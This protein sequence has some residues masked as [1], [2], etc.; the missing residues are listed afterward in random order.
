MDD[1]GLND[2]NNNWIEVK[3]VSTTASLPGSY[4]LALFID[5]AG[6]TNGGIA[7]NTPD[8]SILI[9]ALSP[10]EVALFNRSGASLPTAGN[11]GAVSITATEVCRFDGDDIIVISTTNDSNAY[12]SRIDIIGTVGT[13]SEVDWG[14]DV[15]LIKGCGTTES[16][17]TVYDPNNY[18][19]LTLDEVNDASSFIG[20]PDLPNIALGIQ[21]VGPTVFTSSW[22]NGVPDKTKQAIINGSYVGGTSFESCDLTINP[23]ANINLNSGDAY[24]LVEGNLNINGT[25][26]IGDTESL[27]MTD[28]DATIS[29]QISKTEV[30][31][32]LNNS[33]DYT[34]W[35]SPVNTTT[36]SAFPGVS[37]IFE[38]NTASL[39][40]E[41][42]SSTTM[43]DGQGYIAQAP[44][45]STQHTVTFTGTPYNGLV[46]RPIVFNNDGLD[47][48]YN[49]MG[50]PYPSAIDIDQFISDSNNNEI[51]NDPIDGTIYLWT[52]N[53]AALDNG[54]DP[55]YVRSDYAT[56]NL[57]GG[58]ASANGGAA[59][60]NNIG[61]GQGFFVRSVSNGTVEF[62]NEMRLDDNGDPLSN[63]QFF[64]SSKATAEKDRLW[65]DMTTEEGAFNQ[66]LIG[67]FDKATDNEDRGY[68]GIKLGGGNLTFY[69]K[70]DNDTKYAIQGLG[71]FNPSKEVTL[72]FD[73]SV[74]RTFKI[75]MS[76][77]EGV[78]KDEDVFLLDNATNVLHD[79]K[80]EPYEFEAVEGNYS[81]RFTLKF[82]SGVLSAEDIELNNSFIVYNEN[83]TLK[84]KASDE[85]SK[86]KVFDM[87]GR[88]LLDNEPKTSA[89][90]LPIQN[91]KVGT[92]LIINA[93][94][95][96]GSTISKKAIKY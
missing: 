14:S 39:V 51:F 58:T 78:L 59:P 11:L 67:F 68:D 31:E 83:N 43:N 46:L 23:G 94:M 44:D 77:I 74:D 87:T 85:I 61:S 28:P 71:A 5:T 48:D 19:T 80:L 27:I 76:N 52:H 41:L 88:L 36:A 4:F 25:F 2:G 3:N 75:T 57:A 66:V 86:I 38:W 26:D 69:S 10:G 73:T 15:S 79:L 30:S 45:G 72:G 8:E 29:G 21:T 89:F 17:S 6:T 47:N 70:I 90:D 54:E 93:T 56:Y 64:K 84:I 81:N 42:A 55:D 18:I 95:K 92:V 53:S 16:P 63:T 40:W 37:N 91:I 34:Y 60:T 24:I 7:S 32:P 12:N 22:N 96:N 62:N 9:P 1:T 49:L 35:S 65:L 82:N 13:S 33:R 20:S 50:N